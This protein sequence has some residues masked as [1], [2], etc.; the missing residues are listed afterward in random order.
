[1]NTS[2]VRIARRCSADFQSAVSPNSIQQTAENPG[3][4]GSSTTGGMEIGATKGAHALRSVL[5]R[6]NFTAPRAAPA[7]VFR[8]RAQPRVHR[9]VPDI[10]RNPPSLLV[11]AHPVVKRL[12]LPESPLR[13][14]QH[15][16]RPQRSELLPTIHDLPHQMIWH[17]PHQNMYVVGH[18]HPLAEEIA[19]FVEK[20]E[21][22]SHQVRDVR[23][24]Q[25]AR[26]RALVE[27]SLHLSAEVPLNDLL[28][29][30]CGRAQAPR[31]GQG[32]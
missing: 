23:S 6:P 16:L 17:R 26:A 32:P 5:R 28:W 29:V 22:S 15:S 31:F 10:L 30:R 12:R 8:L 21:R 27:V 20:P 4:W 25:V 19:L 2:H 11:V 7:P 14:S 18:H 13:Q 1:M 9:I 24:A 3:A